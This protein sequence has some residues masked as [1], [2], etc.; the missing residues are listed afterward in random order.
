MNFCP[1][2]EGASKVGIRLD[3]L[4]FLRSKST[5][6]KDDSF[7]FSASFFLTCT[8]EVCVTNSHIADH[9]TITL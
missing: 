9:I 7:S 6:L 4:L 1:W 3:I 5:N 8:R 2:K